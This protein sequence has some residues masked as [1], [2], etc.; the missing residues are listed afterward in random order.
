MD[1]Q[2]IISVRGLQNVVDSGEDTIELVTAGRLRRS[3]AGYVIEYDESELTG[4]EG[5]K[6]AFQVE[7]NRVTLLRSGMVNSQMIF[8][9]GRQHLSMYEIAGG[10]LSIGVNT[11][12][13][14]TNID[15]NGGT[16]DIQ[17]GIDIDNA[18]IGVNTVHLTVK[19][20]TIPQ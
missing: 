11:R 6:T 18:T 16:L 2:V 13:L 4:M 7:P 14:R 12:R 5:T 3:D 19:E 17:Y 20:P 8:E 1:K 15:D 10:A 9:V